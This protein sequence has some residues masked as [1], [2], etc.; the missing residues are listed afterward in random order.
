MDR[1]DGYRVHG[2]RG[3]QEG[4]YREAGSDNLITYV[5]TAAQAGTKSTMKLTKV[6]ER[7]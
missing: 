6:T 1:T 5:K 2:D 7:S 4:G 3:A